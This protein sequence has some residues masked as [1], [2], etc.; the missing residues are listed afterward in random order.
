[1]LYCEFCKKEHNELLIYTDIDTHE[2]KICSEC[3]NKIKADTCINCGKQSKLLY[4][5]ICTNCIQIRDSDEL[6]IQEELEN[7][8]DEAYNENADMP[9]ELYKSWM[10]NGNSFNTKE[11][12]ENNLLIKLWLITKLLYSNITD[13][14]IIADNMD[15]LEILAHNNITR[16]KKDCKIVISNNLNNNQRVIDRV[17]NVILI[18]A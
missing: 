18:E 17:H 14:S 9:D 15:D 7:S 11:D 4:K 12:R 5:G 8:L 3:N 6:V 1:M 10:T 13:S 16:V 2:Y